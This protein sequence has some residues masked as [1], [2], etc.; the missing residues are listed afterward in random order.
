MAG[1]GKSTVSFDGRERRGNEKPNRSL[2]AL[3]D[4]VGA[5]LQRMHR[6]SGFCEEGE[7][8]EGEIERKKAHHVVRV[9]IR[10]AFE[11]HVQLDQQPPPLALL[12]PHH[13]SPRSKVLRARHAEFIRQ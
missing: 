9:H 2:D 3:E 5:G 10:Q 6:V 8:E 4:L 12:Q 11:N 7:T 1:Y 13:V